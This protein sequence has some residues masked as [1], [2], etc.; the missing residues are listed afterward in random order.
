MSS[1]KD[2]IFTSETLQNC[3]METYVSHSVSRAVR[4]RVLNAYGEVEAGI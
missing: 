4:V 3:K 1:I 2:L